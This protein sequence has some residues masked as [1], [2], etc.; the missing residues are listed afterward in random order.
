MNVGDLL[1][2]LN[3]LLALSVT[4][5]N[6]RFWVKCRAKWR[7]IKGMYGVVGLMYVVLY[8]LVLTDNTDNLMAWVRPLITFTLAVMLSG[9]IV[10]EKSRNREC[11]EC[12]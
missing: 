7:W 1:A 5:L 4:V 12:P 9:S 6:F 11:N 3:I 8:G 2:F 10:S